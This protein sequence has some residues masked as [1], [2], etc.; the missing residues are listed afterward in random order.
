MLCAFK[1][2]ESSDIIATCAVLIAVLSMLA[3]SYQAWITR[4]HGRIG[5][6]PHLDFLVRC[7]PG[8]PLTI[9]LHN[10]GIGPALIKSLTCRF[11]G[12]EYDATAALSQF[13][14]EKLRTLSYPTQ[15]AKHSRGTPIGVAQNCTLIG[16]HPSGRR[17]GYICSSKGFD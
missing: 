5:V 13:I 7:L 15:W 11:D 17:C 3:T 16:T 2:L 10:S 1:N 4:S 6:R 8:Q 12:V 9:E 14:Q